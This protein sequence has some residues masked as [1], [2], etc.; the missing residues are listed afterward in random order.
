MFVWLR[1]GPRICKK[2]GAECQNWE[3]LAD[4]DQNRLNLHDL[5]VKRGRPG[6]GLDRPIPGS[7]PVTCLMSSQAH[8]ISY[9]SRILLVGCIGLIQ[10]STAVATAS[11]RWVLW[12]YCV[13]TACIAAPVTGAAEYLQRYFIL[14]NQNGTLLYE[15]CV[16]GRRNLLVYLTTNQVFT[17]CEKMWHHVTWL[18]EWH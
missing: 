9:T 18:S 8:A 2:R 5:A 6:P 16:A 12:G 17:L 11:W 15:T 10:C 14:H 13:A 1:A 7:A 3:K 4:I